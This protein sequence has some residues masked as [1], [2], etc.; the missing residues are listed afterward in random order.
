VFHLLD[1]IHRLRGVEEAG[2]TD[3]VEEISP[4]AHNRDLVLEL[5]Q[6][7]DDRSIVLVNV[8]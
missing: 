8:F 4:L 3:V 5:H 2:V 7:E 6:G 1:A